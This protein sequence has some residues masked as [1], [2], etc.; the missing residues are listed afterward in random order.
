MLLLPGDE[1][2][3][4]LF[5]TTLLEYGIDIDWMGGNEVSEFTFLRDGVA[6]VE[7]DAT[8]DTDDLWEKIDP[9]DDD[10]C[11]LNELS[12][13]NLGLGL[14]GLPLFG[15]GNSVCFNLSFTWEYND[16]LLLFRPLLKELE[17]GRI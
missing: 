17:N 7:R 15:N 4:V 8:D 13:V 10:D 14:F 2:V 9:F 5:T 1:S 11:E 6:V 16:G 3:E 12:L